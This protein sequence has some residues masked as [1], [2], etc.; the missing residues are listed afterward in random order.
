MTMPPREGWKPW[1]R[2]R[3]ARSPNSWFVGARVQ[4]AAISTAS[5][6]LMPLP[7]YMTVPELIAQSS[8][9]STAPEPPAGLI[10]TKASIIVRAPMEIG[11]PRAEASISARAEILAVGSMVSIGGSLAGRAMVRIGRVPLRHDSGR[12]R[13]LDAE[14][15]VVPTRAPAMARLEDA[16]DL[17]EDVGVVR[18]RDEAMGQAPADQQGA[19]VFRRELGP[20]PSAVG[21]AILA[22]VHGHV[23]DRATGHADQLG[24]LVRRRLI[25][26]AAQGGGFQIA[27][28]AGLQ[29]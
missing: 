25:V 6:I 1:S 18:E 9:I 26:Q 20:G 3:L 22:Q 4:L 7:V 16:V 29:R 12:Q 28:Q 8:P 15:R 2:M 27:R 23:E 24:L 11:V 13:P 5:P 19:A 21:R 14:G 17:I 10:F